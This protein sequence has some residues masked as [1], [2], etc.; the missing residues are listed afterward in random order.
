MQF[1]AHMTS[2]VVGSSC[3]DTFLGAPTIVL[4]A[5][6]DICREMKITGLIQRCNQLKKILKYIFTEIW[7]GSRFTGLHF[8]LISTML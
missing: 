2:A 1:V 6:I 5:L 3:V 7:T 8:N 4:F